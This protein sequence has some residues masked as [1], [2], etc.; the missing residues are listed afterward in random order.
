MTDCKR[1]CLLIHAWVTAA[2]TMMTLFR[3]EQHQPLLVKSQGVVVQVK[4]SRHSEQESK[5]QQVA[6]VSNAEASPAAGA[7]HSPPA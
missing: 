3:E 4:E 6:A 2:P 5:R 1:I 7:G